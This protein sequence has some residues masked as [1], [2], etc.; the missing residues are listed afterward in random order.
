MIIIDNNDI[1]D[2]IDTLLLTIN[3]TIN[4]QC[5]NEKNNKFKLKNNETR[6]PV[7]HLK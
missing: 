1:D 7:S 6:R 3:R 4:Q 2:D 5:T